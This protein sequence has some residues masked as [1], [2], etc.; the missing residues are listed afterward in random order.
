V[1]RDD[2]HPGGGAELYPNA[3]NAVSDAGLGRARYQLFDRVCGTQVIQ[4]VVQAIRDGIAEVLI[5]E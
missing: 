3:L 2:G 4:T 1:I 5:G